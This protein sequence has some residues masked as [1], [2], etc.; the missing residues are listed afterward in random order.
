MNLPRI[1][2]VS[3]ILGCRIL[4]TSIRADLIGQYTTK[5]LYEMIGNPQTDKPDQRIYA[6]SH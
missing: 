6:C 1:K 3:V 4:S 2:Y 5:E